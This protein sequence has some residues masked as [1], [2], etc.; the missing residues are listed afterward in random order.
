MTRTFSI[1][2]S[3]GF[4]LH[5]GAALGDTEPLVSIS[6]DPNPPEPGRQSLGL[7]VVS[8]GGGSWTGA[9]PAVQIVM[10]ATPGWRELRNQAEV[11]MLSPG[12]YTATVPVTVSGSW[13]LT[14]RFGGKKSSELVY[15]M[16]TGQAGL[17]RVDAVPEGKRWP[18]LRTQ[19]SR[20]KY[21][22]SP[23]R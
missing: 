10:P 15:K 11:E 8:K 23:S 19:E 7:S 12:R 20:R 5:S 2:L 22:E 4:L 16:Q 13:Y 9:A 21:G 14:I 3:L 17:E 6:M 1:I 18:L